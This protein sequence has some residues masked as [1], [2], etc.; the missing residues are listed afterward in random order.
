MVDILLVEDDDL[1]RDCLHE[2]LEDAGL[3]VADRA[4]AEDALAFL[5]LEGAPCVL[6]TD[7]NLGAG[8][9]GLAFAAAA[10]RRYP[11]LSVIY[12]SG[13]HPRLAGLDHHERFLPKP[14][15]AASLVRAIR[16]VQH[17]TGS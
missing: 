12:I 8:M 5:D 4:S 1:V 11:A 6:V 16:D 10:R 2:A 9:D 15:A 17:V 13:R 7:I 3:V 14:F